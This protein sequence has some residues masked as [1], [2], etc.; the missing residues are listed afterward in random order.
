MDFEQ[1]KLQK[2]QELLAREKN[3]FDDIQQQR[4]TVQAEIREEMQLAEQQKHLTKQNF[5]AKEHAT[6]RAEYRVTNQVQLLQQKMI[7]KNKL[8]QIIAPVL[9]QMDGK[10]YFSLSKRKQ[11]N[12]LK[13]LN[14]TLAKDIT[15]LQKAINFL[16]Q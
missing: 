13:K 9:E 15:L 12:Q 5:F 1:D 7:E 11:R 16:L 6:E 3:V 2:K 10:F 4:K 14:R 8:M